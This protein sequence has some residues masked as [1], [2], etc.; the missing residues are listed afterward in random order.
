MMSPLFKQVLDMMP[1]NKNI[2]KQYYNHDG[3]YF[4]ETANYWGGLPELKPDKL[5]KYTDRYFTPVLEL[6]SMMLDYY[7]YTGNKPFLTDTLLPIINGGLTFFEHHF[8]KDENGKLLL[9]PDNSI[10]MYWD[11]SNPLPDIAGLHYVL[12][13][14][15]TLPANQIGTDMRNDWLRIQKLLPGIP[16]GIKDG[17]TVLLPYEND[18]KNSGPHNTENPELYAIYPFRIY[19]LDKP[20]Y[21]MALQTFNTRL[22]KRSGCW[23]QDPVDEAFLGL[24]NQAKK[25][26]TFNM[27]NGDPRLRF[28]AFWA[29]GHDYMPDEDNGGNGQLALQKMLM[30]CDGKKIL[31]LPAWPK[32]WVADFKLCAPYQTMVEGHVEHGKITE[33]KVSPKN[34]INDIK[35]WQQ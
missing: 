11:V 17:H 3:F 15:L 16:T 35:F 31:L 23:H 32:E 8:P 9:S 34:R 33:L 10:E 27:T 24:S 7:D 29:R 26:V 5:G 18:P 12:D 25:D 4:A 30:Q 2:I 19:G 6:S 21:A 28:P 14:L 13:R 1:G 20:D 22:I